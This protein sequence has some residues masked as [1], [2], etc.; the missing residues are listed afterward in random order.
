MP[1]FIDLV[2]Q[3]FGDLKVLEYV[4]K[5]K[6]LCECEKCHSKKVILG[7]NLRKGRT[8]SCGCLD[9][10]GQRFGKLVVVELHHID[11]K[12]YWLCQC[13]CGNTTI[14]KTN[15]LTSGHTKSCGCLRKDN[16]YVRDIAG[17]RFGNLVA[18]Y[19]SG[20]NDLGRTLW[21]CKCD[22]G[23]ECDVTLGN[24]VNGYTRSCH[25]KITSDAERD[26]VNYVQQITNNIILHDR[27]QLDGKEIDIY[28]SD[29]HIGIEYCGSAFHA[30][31]N[32]VYENKPKNYHQQKF[33]LARSKGIRLL[34]IFDIDFVKERIKQMLSSDY[35]FIPTNEIE[36]TNNDYDIG[37]W[38]KNFGYEEIGQ[39]EPES[40]THKDFVV[41]RCGRTI[42]KKI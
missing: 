23:N 1:K 3:K 42:W 22:C 19:V 18:Q 37:L 10:I 6:W 28:L 26:I 20:K 11:V 27:E 2:G 9:L 33:L 32:A 34:T 8:K 14:V 5:S 15:Q 21:H 16:H 13:D 17:Q 40:F 7:A 36:Y 24:L 38:I 39:E 41:Y 30:S 31:E 29:L 4:G 25:C 12:R 35:F